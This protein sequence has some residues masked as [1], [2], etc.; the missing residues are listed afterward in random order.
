MPT[1]RN[2]ILIIGASSGIGYALALAYARAGW[3]V[4]ATSRRLAQLEQLRQ[5]APAGQLLIRQHD[6][7]APDQMAVVEALAAE[8]GGIAVLVYNA[9][10]GIFNK[11]MDWAPER[12]TI[13][14]N[15]AGF[16][17]TA[18][19]AYRHF[20]A[21]GGGTFV[22]ISSVAALRG[23]GTAPAYSASK[24]FMSSYMEGLRQKAWHDKKQP[25]HIVDIRPG[26]VDTPMTAQNKGMFWVAG[27]DKAARQIMAAIGRRQRVAYITRRWSLVALAFRLAPRWLWERM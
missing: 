19:W 12:D 24:A 22:G 11:K 15:V 2:S 21:Q 7:T 14:V 5:E 1:P 4:G 6:V 25:I 13:A 17:E 8:L 23:G 20:R 3:K 18:T 16:A 10:I 26:Y 9:G 27:P